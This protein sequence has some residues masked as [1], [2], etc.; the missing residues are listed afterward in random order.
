MELSVYHSDTHMISAVMAADHVAQIER[1]Y[2]GG[3]E[4]PGEYPEIPIHVEH[5]AMVSSCVISSFAFVEAFVNET[6]DL[7]NKTGDIEQIISVHEELTG[8][9]FTRYSTLRKYQAIL[10]ATG[11]DPFEKGR[12]PYQ[13]LSWLRQL[14][15][16]W[17]HFEPDVITSDSNPKKEE[18]NLESALRD[19]VEPN[20]LYEHENERYLPRKGLSYSCCEW[21]MS[22][23]TVFVEEFRD[24]IGDNRTLMFLD[25]AESILPEGSKLL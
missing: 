18:S 8:S 15:N 10:V 13:D 12:Q 2:T 4:D 20:P 17:V 21:S 9:D 19:R 7:I 14:R 16:Y 24:K 22:S 6:Y 3:S 11:H 1:E 25:K 5:S 23:A